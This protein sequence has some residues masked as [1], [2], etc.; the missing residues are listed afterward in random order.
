MKAKVPLPNTVDCEYWCQKIRTLAGEHWSA[1]AVALTS[2]EMTCSVH[3]RDIGGFRYTLHVDT[4]VKL[5]ENIS[6]TQSTHHPQ[7]Y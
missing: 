1:G 2:G 5:S 7:L 4:S 3:T 6:S